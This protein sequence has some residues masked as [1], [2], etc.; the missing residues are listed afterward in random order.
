MK[1]ITCQD[2]CVLVNAITIILIKIKLIEPVIF[3]IIH[4]R[5]VMGPRVLIVYP[6]KMKFF[7]IIIYNCKL[8]LFH[9]E[10]IITC[11]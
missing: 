8:Y 3:A 5:H 10:C 9:G 6:V 2:K 4:V 1:I 7:N 11:P